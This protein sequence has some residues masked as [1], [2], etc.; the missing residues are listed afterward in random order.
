[1]IG[2]RGKLIIVAL[3]VIAIGVAGFLAWREYKPEESEQYPNFKKV[4]EDVPGFL[5]GRAEV[6]LPQAPMRGE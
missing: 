3:M 2:L 5:R 4:E 1:M 6:N